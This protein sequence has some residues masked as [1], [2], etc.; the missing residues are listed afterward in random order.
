MALDAEALLKVSQQFLLFRGELFWED[1]FDLGDEAPPA[2]AVDIGDP[3]A[4]EDKLFPIPGAGLEVEFEFATQ[5]WDR[6]ALPE[7]TLGE[8]DWHLDVNVVPFTDKVLIFFDKK[9]DVEIAST[10]IS[11]LIAV[12]LCPEAVAGINAGGDLN[13]D[14]LLPGRVPFAVAAGAAAGRLLPGAV[15]VGT[16]LREGHEPLAHH[17]L[18]LAAA[19]G[20]GLHFA[21]FGSGTVAGFARDFVG[22]GDLF[23]DPKDRFVEAQPQF[24]LEVERVFGRGV[25][26][27]LTAAAKSAAE[28]GVEDVHDVV[29]TAGVKSTPLTLEPLFAVSVV[30]LALLFVA[31]DFIR[32]VDVL[33]RLFSL[34]VTGVFVRVVPDGQFAVSLFDFGAA[35]VAADLQY[36]VIIHRFHCDT[37]FG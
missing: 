19:G 22:D 34:F 5:G 7:N 35:G 15:A 31:E 10:S 3:F 21:P 33:E 25:T 30:D 11:I 12:P 24:D 16:L 28:H 4:V 6:N 20:A 1:H 8:E 29:H 9:G 27:P 26:P 17:H 36:I 23:F 18:P 14:G 13:G 2:T 32:F 37:L